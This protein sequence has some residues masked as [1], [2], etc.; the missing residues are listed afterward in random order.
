MVKIIRISAFF[1]VLL[2]FSLVVLPIPANDYIDEDGEKQFIAY[3]MLHD[4]LFPEWENSTYWQKESIGIGFTAF[5][6]M[7]TDR[8]DDSDYGGGLTYPL[9]VDE[10]NGVYPCE[11]I[12]T[13]AHSGGSTIYYPT[14][15]WQLY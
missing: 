15:G 4:E 7:V 3:G 2:L 10:N 13:P 9:H 8:L 12:A 1:S 6:E 5:G 11:H 14:E